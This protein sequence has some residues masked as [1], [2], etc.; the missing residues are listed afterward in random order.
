MLICKSSSLGITVSNVKSLII[1]NIEIKQCGKAYDV[2]V[3]LHKH[4]M[5]NIPF[6]WRGALYINHST[7]VVIH[8]VSVTISAGVSGMIAINNK[9]D[10][11]IVNFSVTVMCEQLNWI[12]SGIIFYN[13]DYSTTNTNYV[14]TDISYKTKGLC[15]Y[16][17]VLVLSM[18]QEKYT[19]VFEVNNTTLS[20]LHSSSVMYYHSESCGKHNTNI[21]IFKHCEMKRNS[22][23]S[24]LNMFYILIDNKDYTFKHVKSKDREQC[25]KQNIINFKYCN[26]TSNSNMNSLIYANLLT[27]QTIIDIRYS[28]ILNNH[29]VTFIK[30]SSQAGVFWQSSLTINVMYTNISFNTHNG[31]ASLMSLK[32]Q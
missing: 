20:N 4:K 15:K 26:F 11:T 8:N 12:T 32:M 6:Q 9:A 22:G 21:V 13:D 10:F 18:T 14:A 29:N 28:K 5:D 19:T 1:N 27:L 24:D 30:S 3:D 17:I 23:N 16:S 2:Q 7:R 25:N 31:L